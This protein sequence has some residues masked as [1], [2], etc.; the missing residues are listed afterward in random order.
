MPKTAV[1]GCGLSFWGYDV[2][3]DHCL[4]SK[5]SKVPRSDGDAELLLFHP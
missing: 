1:G 5:L 2:T 4:H 3:F